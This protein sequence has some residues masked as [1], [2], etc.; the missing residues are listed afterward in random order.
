MI[1]FIIAR[2]DRVFKTVMIQEPQYSEV[3]GSYGD[4]ESQSSL[5]ALKTTNFCS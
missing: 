2:E 1:F 5:A 3:C 4:R